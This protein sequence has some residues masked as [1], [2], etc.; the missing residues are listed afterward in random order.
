METNQNFALTGSTAGTVA[1]NSMRV[2]FATNEFQT[3]DA[4]EFF[5]M[6]STYFNGNVIR[7]RGN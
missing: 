5:P 4:P 6:G 3:L 7:M 2:E 1:Y